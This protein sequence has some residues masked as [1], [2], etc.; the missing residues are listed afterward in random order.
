MKKGVKSPKK[1]H[2]LDGLMKAPDKNG[3]EIQVIAAAVREK[4]DA[5]IVLYFGPVFRPKDDVLIDE[6][7]QK[8]RRK[9]V[10]LIICTLGGDAHPAYRIARALQKNYCQNGGEVLAFVD[11]ACWSAG[12]LLIMGANRLILSDHAELGPIDVQLRKSEEVGERTSGLTPIQALEF[13]ATESMRVF[14]LQ[15]EQMRFGDDLNFSTKLASGVAAELTGALVGR[16]YDQ[17]DPMRVAEV[18]RTLMIAREYG[19]RIGRNLKEHALDALLMS[20]PSHDFVIDH[21]EAKTLFDQ[22]ESP[23]DELEKLGE[24]LKGRADKYLT[25]KDAL[26]C[27]LEEPPLSES[28]A[29]TSHEKHESNANGST[30]AG[31]GSASSEPGAVPA[32]LQRR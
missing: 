23:S 32:S 11:S 31:S 2:R 18:N 16:L 28:S 24:L 5:D 10:L 3:S 9:N 21:T 30:G 4:Y 22:V 29:T 13:L 1:Q 8:K 7:V 27:Y 26:V 12:T 25:S 19:R 14:T 17:I 20:Y 15:F 6:C